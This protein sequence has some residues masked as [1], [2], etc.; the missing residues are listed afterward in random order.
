MSTGKKVAAWSAITILA[1]S[2]FAG[3]STVDTSTVSAATT[4]PVKITFWHAMAGPYKEALQKRIDAFNKS[5]KQYKVV[6][7]A[8]GDYTTLNQKI[9]AGAKSKTLPVMA[10]ATYTQIP[11]YAKDGIVTSIQSQVTGKNG[12]SKKQL[13]NIYSGFL[14]QSKYKGEYYSTPFSA[15]VREMFYNK[16]LLKKYNLSVPKTWDDI[17]N[18]SEVLKKDGIATVGFDKSFDMEWDSMVRSAGESLVTSG[19]KVNVNSKKAVAAAKLITNMVSDGTAKTAGSDI[20]GTTNFVNG[21]TALTFSSSAGITATRAAAAK[22]FDWGTAPLP[23]YQGKSATVLAGNSLVVT[24]TASKKQQSGAWAFM[25]FLMS[26]KQTEKW[27]EATGY[28]PITKTATKSAAYK[29]YLD[30][31]PLAKAASESLPGAFSDTAFLGYQD[32]RTNLATAVDAMLTKNT[33]ASDALNTLADQTKKTL[34]EN[35]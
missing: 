27:A 15:S 9:M 19:G 14:Q 2:L 13:N 4:K 28:L 26:D 20:Y 17:A 31:N 32:Y 34:Q 18:M 22:D 29:A 11:D 10:Q 24:A 1:S 33:S 23:S 25:K 30:K 8:Q 35:K 5:Q 12:L 16:T 6:A 7:T 3:L 21:K